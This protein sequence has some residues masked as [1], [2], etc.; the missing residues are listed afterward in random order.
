MS[1]KLFPSGRLHFAHIVDLRDCHICSL[2]IFHTPRGSG[3][4]SIE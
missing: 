1:P 3:P 2:L 4:S